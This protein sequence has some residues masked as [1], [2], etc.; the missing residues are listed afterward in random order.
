M[1]DIV[2]ILLSLKKFAQDVRKFSIIE[3]KVKI[4]IALQSKPISP[5]VKFNCG[6]WYSDPNWPETVSTAF[7]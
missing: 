6:F 3:V 1:G 7:R 5:E 4:I 2:I